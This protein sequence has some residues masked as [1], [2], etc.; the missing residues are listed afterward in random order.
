MKDR[1]RLISIISRLLNRDENTLDEQCGVEQIHHG[2]S[3]REFYRIS[4]DG[5]RFVLMVHSGNGEEFSSYIAVDR[6]LAEHDIAVPEIISYSE[7]DTAALLE[8]LGDV[9]LEDVLQ[10]CGHERVE[11]YY[12]RCM[13]ILVHL[14]TEVT[15]GMM[16][17]GFLRGRV[18]SKEKLLHE[19]EY[20]LDEFVNTYCGL[21]VPG[22]I[23]E[24]RILLAESLSKERS[25]FMHRDFQSR[26][27]MVKDNRLYL[28]D[29]QTAH[30]GPWP[31]DVASLLKDAYFSPSKDLRNRLLRELYYSLRERNVFAERSFED[32]HHVFTLA[33]VQRNMQALAAFAK[34]G[35][36]M[37]KTHFLKSIPP[38]LRLLKEGLEEIAGLKHHLSLVQEISVKLE[39]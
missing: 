23:E 3:E 9:H 13:N 5:G 14:Q 39:I 16:K 12:K 32:F 35:A 25:V 24:E 26:N 15:E 37:G 31:Y 4:L 18:F 22:G 36:R 34:L 27:I 6:F 8:D 19:T 21:E 7:N 38:A 33:G 10:E 17:K 2:G 30:R 20:F 11:G 29:F 28:I 1:R